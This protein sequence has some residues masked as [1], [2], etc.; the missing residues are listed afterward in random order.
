[1]E[2]SPAGRGRFNPD[3]LRPK[4]TVHTVVGGSGRVLCLRTTGNAA[5]PDYDT[6]HT[7]T[8]APSVSN[9]IRRPDAAAAASV[10]RS[11]VSTMKPE[12]VQPV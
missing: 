3:G 9:A 6:T 8:S 10:V 5:S 11:R 12:I 2:K 1:M 7:N 4:L